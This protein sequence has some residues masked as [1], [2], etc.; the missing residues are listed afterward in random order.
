MEINES[1]IAP[2]WTTDRTKNNQKLYNDLASNCF[3]W[4][5][6]SSLCV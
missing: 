1:G 6:A 2:V 4:M 3:G 5:I